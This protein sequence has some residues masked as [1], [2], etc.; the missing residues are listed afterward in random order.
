MSHL[1]GKLGARLGD[2]VGLLLGG[3]ADPGGGGAL[4]DRGKVW[5]PTFALDMLVGAG[6]APGLS[7]GT[8]LGAGDD[9]RL[10][11]GR[12]VPTVQVGR[13]HERDDV[14]ARELDGD[15]L[16]EVVTGFS[17]SE[18]RTSATREH[19]ATRCRAI[20]LRHMQCRAR[21]TALTTG[22]HQ[23]GQIAEPP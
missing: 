11:A 21:A 12:Q 13:Q 20:T 1:D 7:L 14:L 3:T 17:A 16:D 18:D 9:R 10:L 8:V 23:S 2:H 4:L 22:V 6:P 15:G 5:C 19:L